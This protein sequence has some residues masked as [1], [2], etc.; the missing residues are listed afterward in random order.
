MP[1]IEVNGKEYVV[2]LAITDAEK[3]VGLQ[4]IN[5]MPENEGMLF[6][7]DEPQ[8]VSYWME[9]TPLPLDIIFINEYGEVIS[10]HQGEPNSEDAIEESDVKYVLEVNVDS[11]IEAGD[12]VDLDDVEDYE[13]SEEEAIDNDEDKEDS[14]MLVLDEKGD[15]QMELEGN[16]R[17]FSRKHTKVL[18]RLSKKAYKSKLD[19][20]YK[21]LGRKIF[22]FIE[23]QNS[24]EQEF[25]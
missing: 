18:A 25:V 5:S 19:K 3:E 6:I 15:V 17:I 24:Q 11:G 9:S 10:V 8:D 7:Y 2:K 20:D 1:R 16:E 22:E 13:E 12:D 14:K 23:R 21:A 4:N